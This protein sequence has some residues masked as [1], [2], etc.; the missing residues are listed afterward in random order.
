MY[1]YE[2]DLNFKAVVGN[3]VTNNYPNITLITG[4]YG[5]GKTEFAQQIGRLIIC[6][7]PSY[8]G[9]CG[10]CDNCK[11]EISIDETFLS[12]ITL[13]DMA[14]KDRDEVKRLIEENVRG[15]TFGKKVYIY[16]EF[17]T[18]PKEDQEK[19]LSGSSRLENSYLILTTTKLNQI[20]KGIVSRSLKIT[21]KPITLTST[22]ELL[23]ERG[24]PDL[25]SNI[26]KLLHKRMNGIPRDILILA[27]F[28]H[29]SNLT[30]EEQIAFIEGEHNI[31]LD[32]I[33]MMVNEKVEYLKEARRLIQANQEYTLV[34]AIEEYLYDL[35][36]LGEEDYK[37]KF[38]LSSR[39]SYD[40]IFLLLE[41]AKTPIV[42]FALILRMALPQT[43]LIERS[44]HQLSMTNERKEEQTEGGLEKW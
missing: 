39:I 40:K 13:L 5:L 44:Q 8:Q 41:K 2:N 14:N 23:L 21:M 30:T 28:L 22:Q 1:L 6:S 34:H 33:F 18:I 32:S 19:W 29:S 9:I 10:V 4:G 15:T 3:I 35:I 16:D 42:F 7:A 12:P 38:I 43:T 24:Y 31:D 37:K 11:R 27:K 26:V 20:D 17:H 36:A 25:E